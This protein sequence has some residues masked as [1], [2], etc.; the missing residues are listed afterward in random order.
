M[1]A[2]ELNQAGLDID[3]W[4]MNGQKYIVIKAKL[5]RLSH[6]SDIKM[7]SISRRQFVDA[8]KNEG[9]DFAM[10]FE[11]ISSRLTI[12][13]RD[14]IHASR[15]IM[16]FGVQFDQGRSFTKV[17]RKKKNSS[18]LE[19]QERVQCSSSNISKRC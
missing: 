7:I 16:I 17:F 15:T 3:W 19:T 11:G 4:R 5:D 10:R 14:V 9:G 1:I 8:F 12:P 2:N 6:Y 18:I 13:W